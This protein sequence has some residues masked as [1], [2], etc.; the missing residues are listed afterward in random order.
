MI[1]L[2]NIEK[3][4]GN[5][6]VLKGINLEI[7]K[8]EFISVMGSS[9]SGKSTLL[10]LV[11]GMDR[12]ERGRIIIDGENITSYTDEELT[13]Y[14]RKKV[15]FIFQFFNLLPNITVFENI[16]MPLLLNGSEDKKTGLEYI[17]RVGLEEKQ[18]AYPYQ[19]SGGE[20]Q[21]VAISR[22]LIHNPEIIL[23]DE[24]T[25]SLDSET[26]KKIM[27]LIKQ[28]VEETEKTV[29]LVTHEHYIAEYAGRML[30]IKDGIIF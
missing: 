27:E 12:P 21:R 1:E 30:R 19:L 9:G 10:N 24:P 13:L 25:G 6:K 7:N 3:S 23:A 18:N 17:K 22:A 5:T 16:M 29:I 4:Y 2:E 15:G 8:G 26:E 20:Q 14:R 11:G 28:L